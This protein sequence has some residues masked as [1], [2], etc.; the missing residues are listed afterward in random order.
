MLWWE[1]DGVEHWLHGYGRYHETYEALDGRWLISSR[2][3]VR[4]PMETGTG[5]RSD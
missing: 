2:R 4:S 3:L 1:D 5:A